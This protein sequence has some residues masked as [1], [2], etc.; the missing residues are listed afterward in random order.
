MLTFWRDGFS[1]NDGP[2]RTGDTE[3]DKQFIDAVRKG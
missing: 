1:V 2:L 3:E